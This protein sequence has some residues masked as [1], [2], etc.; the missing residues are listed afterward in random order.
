MDVGNRPGKQF[1]DHE[2]VRDERQDRDALRARIDP[3]FI[4]TLVGVHNKAYGSRVYTMLIIVDS[5]V[6]VIGS[7]NWS[8]LGV[9]QSR[10]ASVVIHNA[11]AAKHWEHIF[12]YDWQHMADFASLD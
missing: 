9:A 10:D 6:V 11:E 1:I 12:N 8:A 7:Q 3:N 5:S 2:R 4:K